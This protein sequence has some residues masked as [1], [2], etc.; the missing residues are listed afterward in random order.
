[1]LAVGLDIAD[2]WLRWSI[3]GLAVIFLI[4][5]LFRRSARIRRDGDKSVQTRR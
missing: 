4:A 2:E 5:Y 1:V 3:V